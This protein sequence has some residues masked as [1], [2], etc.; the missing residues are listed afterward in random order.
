LLPIGWVSASPIASTGYGRESKEIGY[1]LIDLG[2][3]VTFIG[4]LGDVVIWGAVEEQE[5][6][7]GNKAKILA[8]TKPQSAAAVIESYAKQYGFKAIIGFMDSFGLEYLND[9]NLPVMG[10]I[11]ID[12]PF[13]G[14]M[15]NYLR[16]YYKIIAYSRFG[17]N[18]LLKWYPPSKLGFIPHGVD[19][20]KF[21]PMS[22]KQYED[23]REWMADTSEN[24]DFAPPIPEDAEFIAVEMSA[25]VGPRKLLPLLM[26]T[27]SRFCEQHR[28]AHLFIFTNAYSERG[29]YDL[30]SHRIDLK[31]EKNI[32]FPRYD[33]I[34]Q[35]W[36]DENLRKLLGAADVFVHIAV[37]EGFGLP[38]VEACACGTP[39]IAPRNSA[40]T[41]NVE[42]HGWLV[43]N[44]DEDEYIDFPVYVPTLQEYPVPSQKSLLR[45]L[46]EAYNNPDLVKKYGRKSRRFVVDNYAW[47]V[48]MPQWLEFLERTE[49]ELELFTEL[50]KGLGAPIT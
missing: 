21:R 29:G 26:K 9:L 5:T 42:G 12:G 18:E 13:T 39:P 25:N 11:P 38:L 17:Y 27:W 30:I 48:V 10:Y 2:V 23:A 34:I 15:H 45:M 3:P 22:K 28:K 1:R 49:E 44:I 35:P 24:G 43:E 33:P 40:Q 6:F 31:M 16:N 4:A 50:Y 7:K 46:E 14:K 19:T 8:L 32:H 47:D 36:P 20:E 37:A 41:E